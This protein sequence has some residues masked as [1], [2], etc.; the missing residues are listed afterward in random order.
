M[1]TSNP[2]D[3]NKGNGA[4]DTPA[5]GMP[6]PN[7]T[8]PDASIEPAAQA[9]AATA[10]PLDD[11]DTNETPQSVAPPLPADYEMPDD[12]ANEDPVAKV[13]AWAEA[14]PGL[15]VAAAAGVGLVVG[16]IVTGLFPDP[17][18]PSLAD[19]VE[20]RAKVLSKEAKKRGE[21]LRK[22][23]APLME[24]AGESLQEAL[25]RASE[26]LQQAAGKAG[27]AAEDGYE[28]T[29]DFAETIADAAKVAVTGVLATKIDDWVKR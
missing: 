26:A 12:Y 21:D 13:K 24:D 25:H 22:Q 17:E 5:P 3:T 28:K 2:S 1:A 29:K 27:D 4:A 20:K 9:A 11:I 19:R 15:A 18:P 8:V 16:R 6:D 23:S 10:N 14:H 7:P